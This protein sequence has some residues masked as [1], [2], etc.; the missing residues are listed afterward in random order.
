M[1]FSNAGLQYIRRAVRFSIILAICLLAVQVVFSQI[2]ITQPSANAR[3]IAQ[4]QFTIRWTGTTANELVRIEFS[5]DNGRTWQLVTDSARGGEYVW[6]PV[7]VLVSEQ[8]ILRIVTSSQDVT[9]FV[10][11]NA[12]SL[13]YG[14]N[15]S[16]RT[17]RSR[18]AAISPDGTKILSF[19][20]NFNNNPNDSIQNYQMQ[21]WDALTGK[22]EIIQ[23]ASFLTNVNAF[24][25]TRWQWSENSSPWLRYWWS[26]DSRQYISPFNT[27]TTFGIFSI[28]KAKDG[29]P[30]RS[31]NLPVLGK[32]RALR[33][34]RWFRNGTEILADVLYR[35]A[36]T[37]SMMIA[38][39]RFNPFIGT[40]IASVSVPM[41]ERTQ[42]EIITFAGYNNAG[43]QYV[44][45]HQDRL[46]GEDVKLTIYDVI[47]GNITATLLPPNGFRW[48]QY[49]NSGYSGLWSPDDMY[50]AM[51]AEPK[52][53][54]SQP[55][56]VPETVVLKADNGEILRRIPSTP[57][58]EP[59]IWSSNSQNILLFSGDTSTRTVYNIKNGQT[60]PNLVLNNLSTT[61]FPGAGA[62]N[63][64]PLN[65]AW[66]NNMRRIA[67]Y[68][69]PLDGTFNPANPLLGIWDA[70]LGCLLQTVR[71]PISNLNDS[72][73]RPLGWTGSV[74]WSADD[75]R[76]LI[77]N[78]FSDT[79]LIIPIATNNSSCRQSELDNTFTLGRRNDFIVQEFSPF[80]SI[81]CQTAATLKVPIQNITFVTQSI[82]VGLQ[83]ADGSI[84]PVQ[85]FR[86][87]SAPSILAPN[88]TGDVSVQFTPSSAG[89]K[90]AYL[91]FNLGSSTTIRSLLIAVRDS[92]DLSFQPPLADFGLQP[93]NTSTTTS[94]IV[95]NLGTS[96]IQ[97]N[98]TSTLSSSGRFWVESVTPNITQPNQESRAI[99]RFSG[100]PIPTNIVDSLPFFQCLSRTYSLPLQTR[101]LPNAAKAEIADSLSFG[102]L[103][104][105]TSSE[106]TLRIRNV[107]GRN[108]EAFSGGF[109][110]SSFRF[111]NTSFPFTLA[112][113]E[114]KDI[115][116]IFQSQSVGKTT[117]TLFL[118]TNDI[119]RVSIPILLRAEQQKLDYTLADSVVAFDNVSEG[120]QSVKETL[121]TNKT[122]SIT[123]I[124]NF[125]FRVTND[126]VLESAV[127]SIIAPNG[128]SVFRF[129]FLGRNQSVEFTTSGSVQLFDNCSTLFPITFFARVGETRARLS[130]Q[131]VLSFDTISCDASVS[132]TKELSLLLR[133]TGGREVIIE[134]A[135]VD[136]PTNAI[137]QAFSI[138]NAPTKT[139][140]LRIPPQGIT[141][142]TQNTASLRVLFAPQ[143]V[144]Q[145]NLILRLL[146]ND[147][148]TTQS[149]EQRVALIGTRDSVGFSLN[150]SSIT[151]G[152][153]QERVASLDTILITNTG[154]TLLQWEATPRRIND[155]FTILA[156]E[157]SQ[158]PIGG[159]SRIIIRFEGG[160]VGLNEM[161]SFSLS[162]LQCRLR[163]QTIMLRGIVGRQ[164]II[165]VANSIYSEITCD[166]LS[167]ISIPIRNIGSEILELQAPQILSN[168]NLFQLVRFPRTIPPAG[169][170][171]IILRFTSNNVGVFSTRIQINSNS[172]NAASQE[173]ALM[174]RKDSVGIR[175]VPALA[176]FG[177]LGLSSSSTLQISLENTGNVSQTL[178]LPSRIGAF[179]I[180][181]P[182]GQV[183]NSIQLA[184]QTSVPLTIRFTASS[185]GTFSNELVI[186]DSCRRN[187]RLPI[188]AR[189]ITGQ[190]VIP[191]TISLG[192]GQELSVPIRILGR[193]GITANTTVSFRVTVANASMLEIR[194]PMPER[195]RIERG[196][197]ILTFVVR[198]P[199]ES[200]TVPIVQLNLRGLLGNDTLTTITLDSV[201]IGNVQL[202]GSQARFQAIGLNSSSGK[203]RLY[204]TSPVIVQALAP[205][206]SNDGITL[207][208][209]VLEPS[210]V[211][212]FLVDVLGR[213]T[214]LQEEKVHEGT[215]SFYVPLKDVT[216]GVYIVEL[217]TNN[218]RQGMYVQVWK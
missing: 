106:A 156:I 139:N 98:T 28:A 142:S 71:L 149:G 41:R 100:A 185:A 11:S 155:I 125:P 87:L 122:N 12:F 202:R 186:L 23:A 160:S 16:T 61:R 57:T 56:N 124:R 62:F 184:P 197:R 97:W 123:E 76:L 105:Q 158:T 10:L 70:E 110:N 64:N 22:L 199:N 188:T 178:S 3:I 204:Y 99:I 55:I 9:P 90:T 88:Q 190:M 213:R 53:N 111:F 138:V 79:T 27:D 179:T 211:Q 198:I 21:I 114:T 101:I 159:T 104:C 34:L 32:R 81:S 6:N 170:D 131:N 42:S 83:Q 115:R 166:S 130:V 187:L 180:E 172:L 107:G 154:T 217:V 40:S 218:I 69:R 145:Y 176:D 43:T 25:V 46:S 92:V 157:P 33:Q 49:A 51:V 129:R 208:T 30:D 194:N 17:A 192:Q 14:S 113:L 215:K 89:R 86:I 174:L 117:A 195:S 173:I 37:D 50:L 175:F 207:Y 112:P 15:K 209:K 134:S 65:V 163:S 109:S 133:N 167:Q 39:V 95:K 20:N 102:V 126:I 108:L 58:V 35:D 144:G 26:P 216:S 82:S 191:E 24:P 146:S 73:A 48:R 7:P 177:Y 136:M 153:S 183:Q 74:T 60:A 196:A 1:K 132:P 181:T 78:F 18:F 96:A 52:P 182:Q 210:S 67:G 5:A 66:S 169:T 68:I 164:P 8:C 148:I 161:T 121:F 152:T 2:T 147:T 91:S 200:D 127:P 137:N 193:N 44:K 118:Q 84:N 54:N 38:I 85:D 140:P 201:F 165:S 47:T 116:I 13:T 214:L 80:P 168:T 4:G 203:P 59:V 143:Q 206:P 72:I 75:S 19:A 119:D 63:H 93:A 162:P 29:Q 36:A 141:G 45:V 151:F 103:L 205:N 128:R 171:S 189:V 212:V 31:I 77:Q 94:I 150:R 135:N 120:Q